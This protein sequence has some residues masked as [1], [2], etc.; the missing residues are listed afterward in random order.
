MQLFVLLDHLVRPLVLVDWRP[1]RPLIFVGE[2]I[3]AHTVRMA[4]AAFLVNGLVSLITTCILVLAILR[5]SLIVNLRSSQLVAVDKKYAKEKI[6]N[7]PVNHH[8]HCPGNS[9]ERN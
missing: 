9:Y 3:G 2:G 6:A 5:C 1:R 7:C 8:S 4:F